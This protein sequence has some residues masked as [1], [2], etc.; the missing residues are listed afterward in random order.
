VVVSEESGTISLVMAGKMTVN[1]DSETLEEML[2]L[3]GTKAP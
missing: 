1:L 3:Y 2:A